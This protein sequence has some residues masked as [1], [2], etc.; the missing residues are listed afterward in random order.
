MC[1]ISK[2]LNANIDDLVLQARASHLN[3]HINFDSI[4][5][6][7]CEPLCDWDFESLDDAKERMAELYDAGFESQIRLCALNHDGEYEI[8]DADPLY[9]TPGFYDKC[10]RVNHWITG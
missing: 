5:W 9:V 3:R 4:K 6:C 10:E 7:V 1:D 8:A 2:F